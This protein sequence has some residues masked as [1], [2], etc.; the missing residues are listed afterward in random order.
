M[1]HTYTG[2]GQNEPYLHRHRPEQTILTQASARTNHTY[3][4]IG[5][6]EPGDGDHSTNREHN[7]VLSVHSVACC[8]NQDHHADL[9]H[10]TDYLVTASVQTSLF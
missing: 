10:S 9:S 7:N 3:T 8:Q 1:N 6:N 4:G 2:I 5:Q